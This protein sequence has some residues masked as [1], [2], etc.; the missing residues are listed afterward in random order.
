MIVNCNDIEH[1]TLC[2]Y[3]KYWLSGVVVMMSD[4]QLV[5]VGSNPGHSIAI[6]SEVGDH[7]W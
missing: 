5:V 6:F 2:I 1:T 4:L 3:G 7:L